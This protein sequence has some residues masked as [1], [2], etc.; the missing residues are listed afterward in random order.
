MATAHEEIIDLSKDE[1]VI[2][3]TNGGE[4]VIDLSQP[5]TTNVDRLESLGV[6]VTPRQDAEITSEGQAIP[7]PT[8]VFGSTLQVIG[9]AVAPVVRPIKE[10]IDKAIQI[11]TGDT[12]EAMQAKQMAVAER[13]NVVE[14]PVPGT[15]PVRILSPVAVIRYQGIIKEALGDPTFRKWGGRTVDETKLTEEE[16]EKR[17]RYLIANQGMR[18]HINKLS[19]KNKFKAPDE[20]VTQAELD[21]FGIPGPRERS[22]AADGTPLISEQELGA[23]SYQYGV[24]V[25]FLEHR[26]ASLRAYREGTEDEVAAGLGVAGGQVAQIFSGAQL[27]ADTGLFPHKPNETEA[28]LALQTIIEERR[29]PWASA[30]DM[31]TAMGGAALTHT[32]A[33]GIMKASRILGLGPSSG[34]ALVF[35]ADVAD[36][37]V[38]GAAAGRNLQK[39]DEAYSSSAALPLAISTA[40]VIPSALAF[41]KVPLTKSWKIL[42]NKNTEAVL[43]AK[44]RACFNAAIRASEE[45]KLLAPHLEQKFKGYASQQDVKLSDMEKDIAKKLGAKGDDKEMIAYV[46][47]R[48]RMQ[49]ALLE[50]VTADYLTL[51]K[52]DQWLT[53]Y[54]S[55]KP[56]RGANLMA[57][58]A[59]MGSASY[60]NAHIYDKK[61]GTRGGE[62]QVALHN[63]ARAESITFADRMDESLDTMK[64]IARLKPQNMDQRT[65]EA[66]I[67]DH[68]DGRAVSNDPNIVAAAKEV[69]ALLD[70][71][72]QFYNATGKVNIDDLMVKAKDDATGQPTAYIMR[73]LLPANELA[74]KAKDKIQQ[75]FS[76]AGGQ[77]DVTRLFEAGTKRDWQALGAMMGH[78]QSKDLLPVL[79]IVHGKELKTVADFEQAMRETLDPNAGWV[80]EFS[81]ANPATA[82]ALQSR[83]GILPDWAI[84]KNLGRIMAGYVDDFNKLLFVEPYVRAY[85]HF[86][87]V[88]RADATARVAGL[89]G[90]KRATAI[91]ND[92]AV[93]FFEQQANTLRYGGNAQARGIGDWTNKISSSIDLNLTQREHALRQAGETKAADRTKAVKEAVPAALDFMNRNIYSAF[94]GLHNTKAAAQ[95]FATPLFGTMGEEGL[96]YG[97]ELFMRSIKA[98]TKRFVQTGGLK[99]S[100][101]GREPGRKSLRSL[102]SAG[103]SDRQN[104]ELREIARGEYEKAVKTEQRGALSVE[105]FQTA[106]MALFNLSE[107]F[108]REMAYAMGEE[109]AQDLMAGKASAIASMR[110]MPGTLPRSVEQMVSNVR[111]GTMAPEQLKHFLGGHMV[112]RT[113]LNYDDISKAQIAHFMGSAAS[114]F[115]RWPTE[116]VGMLNY[117]V[118]ADP[119]QIPANIA[120]FAAKYLPGLTALGAATKFILNGEDKKEMGGR[121][122]AMIGSTGLEG[123]SPLYGPLSEAGEVLTG[124]KTGGI[125]YTPPV[126]SAG[127]TGV[128]AAG[129]LAF[130]EEGEGVEAA[131]DLAD[132]LAKYLVPGYGMA[133]G[134]YKAKQMW[135]EDEAKP[136]EWY[137]D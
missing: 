137:E 129:K 75:V 99:A 128:K 110:S 48:V 64:S 80:R 135:A 63:A 121:A 127:M 103:L 35:G 76:A 16:K 89:T 30:A 108:S 10:G 57:R 55:G 132:I 100:V 94:L 115:T 97:G 33:S 15:E 47:E 92:P 67:F 78:Q 131:K 119:G 58:M 25:E 111:K 40:A 101:T 117:A 1:E 27:A 44:P 79:E 42:Q 17:A 4:E 2:D 38:Q 65:W 130:G 136:T 14:I 5:E 72:R 59:D 18:T 8:D 62:T 123:W 86:A 9:K 23:L 87:D 82:R 88:A 91:D 70:N 125:K 81:T 6:Q 83:K 118:R 116:T 102:V 20:R 120:R 37:I 114:Q 53:K 45:A 24:P 11:T 96:V 34:Q 61:L 29:S 56:S 39:I 36:N 60:W 122:K 50:P 133:G 98:A 7:D 105:A 22:K 71:W 68:M 109:L 112:E 113:V 85:T 32:Y 84:D 66:V 21:T 93:R 28:L 43:R 46:N 41:T 95:N 19:T 77:G 134:M 104:K 73:R 69:T 90:D 51:Q 49:P 3:L 12:M 13:A 126:V 52:F 54:V 74:V 31:A 124:G 106:T 107:R 26:L